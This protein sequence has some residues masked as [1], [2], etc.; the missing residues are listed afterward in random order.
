MNI[1]QQTKCFK[2]CSHLRQATLIIM[3][4]F[5]VWF[6][7]FKLKYKS[8]LV[9]SEKYVTDLSV[10]FLNLQNC[11]TL[12]K[13]CHYCNQ[14]YKNIY[15]QH[16]WSLTGEI[17]IDHRTFSSYKPSTTSC[18]VRGWKVFKHLVFLILKNTIITAKVSYSAL[19]HVSKFDN[20]AY[21]FQS[22]LQMNVMWESSIFFPKFLMSNTNSE[23]MLSMICWQKL[24]KYCGYIRICH[25][26]G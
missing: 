23:V 18:Q 11:L 5:T 22:K 16:Q 25:V 13:K 8:W 7:R 4:S 1:R 2:F 19:E 21:P 3:L 26:F 24:D 9:I 20:Y 17:R 10:S 14:Q 6:V 12:L 15:A